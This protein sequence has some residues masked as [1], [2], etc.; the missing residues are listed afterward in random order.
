MAARGNN[1]QRFRLTTAVA[2]SGT[3]H[4]EEIFL[5]YASAAKDPDPEDALRE[6]FVRCQKDH[7][8]GR[9][10]T[11]GTLIHEAQL[12]GA[13]SIRGKTKSSTSAPSGEHDSLAGKYWEICCD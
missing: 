13:T 2:R 11:V 7:P 9:G 10:I 5:K 12:Q 4:A 6:H 8:R 3:P 1:D